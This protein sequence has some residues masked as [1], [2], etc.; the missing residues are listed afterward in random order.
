[1]LL[2]TDHWVSALSQ[3][4]YLHSILTQSNK[5]FRPFQLDHRVETLP[6][7]MLALWAKP[8]YASMSFISVQLGYEDSFLCH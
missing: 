1:M 5:L 7:A 6:R 3:T 2:L 8:E 4:S